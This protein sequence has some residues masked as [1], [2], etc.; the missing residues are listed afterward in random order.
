MFNIGYRI[1][2]KN[3]NPYCLQGEIHH[4]SQSSILWDTFNLT[5]IQW[6]SCQ[7]KDELV[8]VIVTSTHTLSSN[9]LFQY[10]SKK[11]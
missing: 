2:S 10:D 11:L 6:L 8:Y 3:Y 1:K 5:D 9:T 4:F 7:P